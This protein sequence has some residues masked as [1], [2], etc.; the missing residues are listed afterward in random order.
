MAD[1]TK[2]MTETEVVAALNKGAIGVLPTDTVYGICAQAASK[3]AVARLYSVKYRPNKRGT[4]LAG[5]V[6]QLVQIGFKRRYLTAIQ[7]FWPGPIS[8]E[9]PCVDL[10]YLNNGLGTIAVR[11]PADDR[12]QQILRHTGALLTSSANQ[13]GEPPATIIQA[14]I[15]YF[16]DTVDFYLDGGDLSG[17]QSSTIIR[18]VDDAIEVIRAGAIK[19]DET[20]GRIAS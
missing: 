17:R 7:H 4:I 6:D 12:L 5:S 3:T 9:I 10:A 16:G 11:I 14:A 19:I 20:T 1:K 18:V 15:D 2:T 8:V 13:P